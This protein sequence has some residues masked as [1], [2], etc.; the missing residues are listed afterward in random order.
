MNIVFSFADEVQTRVPRPKQ[1]A[2]GFTV[3]A[4]EPF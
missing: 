1:L 4:V 2:A 3:I